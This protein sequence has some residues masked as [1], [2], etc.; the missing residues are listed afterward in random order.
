MDDQYVDFDA[1]QTE[2]EMMDALLKELRSLAFID[3][4]G[5]YDSAGR[6]KNVHEMAPAVRRAVA[7]IEVD[8]IWSGTGAAREI[9]GL[10]KKV[11]LWDKKGSIETFMKHLGMFVERI[12]KTTKVEITVQK[13]DLDERI[14]LLTGDR[15]SQRN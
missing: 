6:L 8:E 4:A 9:V 12:E 14:A 13:I 2:G 11:K 15:C 10:T 3:I 7:S 5:L 1:P